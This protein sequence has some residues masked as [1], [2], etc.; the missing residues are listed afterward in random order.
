MI[1]FQ[2][3]LAMYS[4]ITRLF[5]V[6]LLTILVSSWVHADEIHIA[7]QPS[8]FDAPIFVAKHK[9]WVKEELAKVGAVPAIQWSSFAAGPPMNESFAAGQQDIGFLGDTP[10]IISK[11]AGID[12][13][14]IGLTASGPKTLAVIIPSGSKIRS[15]KDL[16]GK[17]VAV[18]KGS[19]A[20]HLLALV[21]K[22]GGLTTNDIKFINMSQADISTAIVNGDIDA[23]AVWEPLIS[24]LESHGAVRVLADG[25][26]IKKGILAI[27]ATSDFATK[28]REQ[29]KAVLRAYRRGAQF[30]RANPK[31]AALLVTADV[32]LASPLLL[33]VLPK[34]DFNPVL[35]SEDIGELK[36][37]EAF[38]RNA[39]IIRTPVN[40]DS[41]VDIS[42]TRE[43][44]HK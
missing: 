23:A 17:K 43:L 40:I 11:S 36:K 32:H 21:L 31:E 28:H 15:P 33:K 25:T 7:T 16:K 37:S 42:L 41:F 27:I 34:F 22:E 18:A 3:R 19:Y 38:M 14:I 29:V 39:A 35:K 10:A 2:G 8:P 44:E 24:T 9:G 1:A 13:K 4:I 20:H 26:G 12:T 5:P 6:A 30:I